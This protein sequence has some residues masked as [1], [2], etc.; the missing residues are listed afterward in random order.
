MP[1]SN[2]FADRVKIS[3]DKLKP[4]PEQI[5]NIHNNLRRMI[6]QFDSPGP[7]MAHNFMNRMKWTKFRAR[8]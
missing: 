1:K 7:E 5:Y 8:H 6:N 3:L 2:N 4:G